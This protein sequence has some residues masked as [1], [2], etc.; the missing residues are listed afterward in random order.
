MLD[1]YP[2]S[3]RLSMIL[4]LALVAVTSTALA[5]PPA[6]FPPFNANNVPPDTPLRIAISTPTLA[7][8]TGKIE[9]C[10]AADNSVAATIDLAQPTRT[11]AIGGLPNYVVRTVLLTNIDA[12]IYLPP[13]ALTYGKTYY[14][15]VPPTA[16][17][18]LGWQGTD[19]ADS[20]AWQFSTQAAPPAAAAPR[21]VVAADGSGDFAT[22][23]AAIDFI[24]E[25]NK[26]P[27]LIFIH[28]GTYQE[29]LCLMGRDH[30]TF[31]GEDRKNTIIAYANNDR[32]N[33]NA[34]GNPFA[35]GAPH[36]GTVDPK[37][38]PVYRRGVFLAHRV[39]DLTLANLT[40]HN[41]TPKGGSQAETIILNVSPD[42]GHVLLT[43]LDLLSYQ[44]T[45]Q[46]NG[47]TY[48]SES[49]IEGDVDF[50]WGTGPCFFQ[51]VR[52]RAVTNGAIFT[53][54]RCPPPTPASPNTNHG[55]IFKD[56]TF[57]GAPDVTGAFLARIEANRFPTS[58]TILLNTM[59]TAVVSP[60]AWRAPTGGDASNVHF[61]EYNSR[62]QEGKPVDVAR[63]LPSSKQLTD[64]ADKDIIAN[65]S[66]PKFVLN[67]ATAPA[68]WTPI[69]AP[70]IA[71]APAD[72]TAR[73]GSAH[74]LDVQAVAIPAPTYQWQKNGT[75][76][77]GAISP[78]LRLEKFSPTDA[79]VYTIIVSNSAGSVTSAAA[80]LT[81][82]T[83]PAGP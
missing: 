25:G 51:S 75:N 28:S 37:T 57:Y 40:I 32:F 35:I 43:N 12:T 48:I 13:H 53:T 24:P 22:I 74:T 50:M 36:P 39:S 68:P 45:V 8:G 81:V 33:P 70:L 76:I 7:L 34:G 41:T 38:G 62:D 69:L 26:V 73:P 17:T 80:R 47:Q 21:L 58:E 82:A 16:F 6:F 27:R 83:G 52:A 77:A 63:R 46:F 10:D 20:K 2:V 64:A 49:Y 9:I 14:V 78:F 67:P 29:I 54:V 72:A 44:D 60:A 30:L 15:K 11:Q 55:F 5:E 71:C 61:W 19:L 3:R 79:G 66:N 42:S 4:A 1:A 59:M 56:C 18:G 65:Y 23:Q 31:L